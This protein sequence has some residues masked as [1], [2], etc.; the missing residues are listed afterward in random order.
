MRKKNNP[1]QEYG[2][3]WTSTSKALPTEIREVLTRS[4]N[5]W[6]GFTEPLILRRKGEYWFFPDWTQRVYQVPLEWKY[7]NQNE[8]KQ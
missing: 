8:N 1:Q 2:I 3:D 6:N 4:H 7:A 5:L